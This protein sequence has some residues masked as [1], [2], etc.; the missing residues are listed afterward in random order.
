M[1][2][3]SG[4]DS[5]QSARRVQ[6]TPTWLIGLHDGQLLILCSTCLH[7]GDFDVAAFSERDATYSAGIERCGSCETPRPRLAAPLLVEDAVVVDPLMAKA[8]MLQQMLDGWRA[9]H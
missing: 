3:T 5:P 8:R 1:S 7:D 2:G 6:R 9:R 4:S